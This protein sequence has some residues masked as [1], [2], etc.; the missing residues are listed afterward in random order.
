[1]LV[2]TVVDEDGDGVSIAPPA[3]L[4]SAI[5]LGAEVMSGPGAALAVGEATHSPSVVEAS[6]PAGIEGV[7]E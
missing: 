4:A 2:I 7:A 5:G 1:V 3:P 6:P